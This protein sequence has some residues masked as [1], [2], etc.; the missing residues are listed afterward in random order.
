[1]LAVIDIVTKLATVDRRLDKVTAKI[2][3]ITYKDTSDED[4][5]EHAAAPLAASQD[6]NPEAAQIATA[7]AITEGAPQNVLNLVIF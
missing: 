2:N 3:A 6:N 5:D 1:M 4:E 7:K